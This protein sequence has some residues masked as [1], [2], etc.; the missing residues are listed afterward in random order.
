MLYILC[1][2]QIT[3]HMKGGQTKVNQQINQK[4]FHLPY[5]YT[6]TIYYEYSS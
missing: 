5:I 1:H 3:K 2:L 6:D 4:C